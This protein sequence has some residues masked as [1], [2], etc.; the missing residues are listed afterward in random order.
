[1]VRL[2]PLSTNQIVEPRFYYKPATMGPSSLQQAVA[3]SQ[4]KTAKGQFENCFSNGLDLSEFTIQGK[5][6][7]EG[8]K[9]SAAQALLLVKAKEKE[10][11]EQQ[12]EEDTKLENLVKKQVESFVDNSAMKNNQSNGGDCLRVPRPSSPNSAEP[13]ML[14]KGG[15]MDALVGMHSLDKQDERFQNNKHMRLA[16][17]TQRN[18]HKQSRPRLKQR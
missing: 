5:P 16:K 15:V 10:Q 18:K 2:L 1:M 7:I 14:P 11:V 13:N 8:A 3:I 4:V 12:A 6:T 9:V 17:K